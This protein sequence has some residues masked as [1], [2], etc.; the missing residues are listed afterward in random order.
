MTEK[1][2]IPAKAAFAMILRGARDHARTPMQWDSTVNGGFNAGAEPWQCVNPAYRE[3]NAAAD[4]AS[5][6]SVYRFY[7]KLLAI[8]KSEPVLLNGDTIEY[9]PDNR[10]I[11]SYSRSYKG[12]RMLIAGNFSGRSHTFTIPGDFNTGD[13]RIELSNYDGQVIDRTMKLRPYEAILFRERW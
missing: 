11:I 8:R 9:D 13:L 5:E 1:L 2:H 3:I 6:R 7:Q 4:M 12:E 10:N